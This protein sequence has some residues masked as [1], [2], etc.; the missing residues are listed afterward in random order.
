MPRLPA[1]Q[2]SLDEIRNLVR[3][4]NKMTTIKGVDQRKRADLIA[5]IH[6]LGYSIDHE[7][8][9]L[10]RTKIGLKKVKK[11]PDI[12]LETTGE[13]KPQKKTIK[14]A[15]RQALITGGS[16]PVLTFDRG[17]DVI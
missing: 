14:K 12:T 2:L 13:P 6:K 5:D 11:R 16:A 3:Q 15:K 10:Y 4:H 9:K 8:K 7:N 17:E 1:G